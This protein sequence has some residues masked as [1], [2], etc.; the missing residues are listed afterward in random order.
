MDLG[1]PIAEGNTAEIY[2]Y[3]QKIYKVFKDYLP[4]DESVNEA[5]KQKIAYSYGLRVPKVFEVTKINGK[6][7]IIMEYIKGETLGGLLLKDRDRAEHYLSLSIDMQL[8][9]HNI[10]PD[11]IEPMYN[12]LYR[13]INSVNILEG[14]LKTALLKKMESF[15]FENRLCHGDFHLFNLIQTDS[16][17]VVIDWVDSNMGDVRAD[18]YRTYLLYSQFSSE[19]ADLYLRLYSEKSGILISEIL[20][21]APIIA[22]TRLSKNVSPENSEQLIKIIEHYCS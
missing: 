21:W 13:Q 3:D 4:D 10:I 22:A 20:Q 19:I 18:V 17:M 11:S 7:V 16:E 12:K 6:Q 1:N 8:E 15:T 14:R 9:I 5:K 2:L